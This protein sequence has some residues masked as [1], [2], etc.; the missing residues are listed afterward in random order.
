MKKNTL[1]FKGMGAVEING[2]KNCRIRTEYID[3]NNNK[4]FVELTAGSPRKTDKSQKTLYF[5]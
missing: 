3:T 4:H 2:V 1:E 5:L